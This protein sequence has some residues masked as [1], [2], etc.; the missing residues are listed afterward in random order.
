MEEEG[1][2]KVYVD[3]PN[4]WAIGGESLWAT[5]LG[6]DL[7][8][9]ENVPFYAYGL[10]FHDIV[11]ATSDSSEYKPEIRE[12]I[13]YSGHRTFRVFFEKTINKAKQEEI[14]D[15][16]E[17]LKVSYERAN[18]IYFSLDLK[19]ESDYQAVFDK[20]EEYERNYVLGFE[21]CDAKIEGSFDDLPEGSE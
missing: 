9:L 6:K 2:E 13:E 16:M 4:H 12:V 18:G 1:L 3:L 11:R 8:R 5:P 7:F 19:P 21:T 14:L 20:L 15:S 17:S 10:N